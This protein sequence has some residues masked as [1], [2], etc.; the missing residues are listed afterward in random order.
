MYQQSQAINQYQGFELGPIRPPSEAGSLLL[1]VTR[2]CPWNKCTFCGLYKGEK[3]SIRPVDH[4]NKDIDRVRYF[5]DEINRALS[6]ASDTSNNLTA[7][8]IGLSAS[9]RLAFHSA[10]NWMRGG[11]KSVFLQD[12]NTLVLKPDD[13]VVILEHLRQVFPKVERVTSYA[14]SHSIARISDENMIRLAAV[15]LNRIHV[16][17][18]SGCNEVLDFI[19]KGVT[20]VWWATL[21]NIGNKCMFFAGKSTY[22]QY[23]VKQLT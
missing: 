6:E 8:Q 13:L 20:I 7:L 15:G 4:V 16:G 21:Y 11:M 17:M 9:D 1:R 14:R 19:R 12:A 23:F 10:F 22:F 18:E 2:N 3:F 5:V